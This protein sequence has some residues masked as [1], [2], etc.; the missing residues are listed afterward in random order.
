MLNKIVVQWIEDP[1]QA[2]VWFVAL[3]ATP[4]T[5]GLGRL[6][7][8]GLIVGATISELIA[9]KVL[10]PFRAFAPS[11]PDLAGVRTI[12][13]DFHEGE[14]AERCDTAKLVGDVIGEWLKRGE[15]RPTLA[16][17]VNRKHAQHIQQQF[18]EVG[19]ACEYVDAFVDR[20]ERELI[21]ERFR[22]GETKI[23]SSVAT[24][25]VGIDL[26]M[27]ACIVDARPTRSRMAFVQRF[28]RGL[29]AAPNKVDCIY[30]D[31][32]GNC[33]NSAFRPTSTKITSTT[34]PRRRARKNRRPKSAPSRVRSCAT[35]ATA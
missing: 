5:V 6:Y 20:R 30:I 25:E 17:A 21:F 10:T 22:R 27:T 31:H 19:V 26:P 3:S 28:G 29:R 32:G 23:I 33:L 1:D 35:S 14:L 16:F 11:E 24:L 12:A 18:L 4:W 2:H 34:E 13:G 8:G 15:G 9:A 7:T